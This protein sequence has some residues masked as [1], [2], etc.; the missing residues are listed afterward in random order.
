MEPARVTCR[1]SAS[2]RVG[3]GGLESGG[4]EQQLLTRPLL[5]RPISS[6]TRT[7]RSAVPAF[8]TARRK[9]PAGSAVFVGR[10]DELT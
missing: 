5:G 3:L 7:S 6:A 8:V 9:V 4:D 2:R 10:S 1:T